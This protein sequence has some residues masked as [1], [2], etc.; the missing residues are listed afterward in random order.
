MSAL[1]LLTWIAGWDWCLTVWNP[2]PRPLSVLAA[3]ATD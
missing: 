1:P 2:V 3:S